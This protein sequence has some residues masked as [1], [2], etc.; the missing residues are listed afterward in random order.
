MAD[1][2][3]GEPRNA[4]FAARTPFYNPRCVNFVANAAFNKS[5]IAD[6]VIALNKNLE[7]QIS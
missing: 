5:R 7:V 4:N 6:F 3:F 2:E 1:K